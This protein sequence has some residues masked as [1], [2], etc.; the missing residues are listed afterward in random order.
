MGACVHTLSMTKNACV[1]IL[2]SVFVSVMF[3]MALKTLF[4]HLL[5]CGLVPQYPMTS[6]DHENSTVYNIYISV[7]A[8]RSSR[9]FVQ[10]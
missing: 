1:Y 4:V 7:C 3:I 5:F 2:G 6:K 8:L 10:G 9:G